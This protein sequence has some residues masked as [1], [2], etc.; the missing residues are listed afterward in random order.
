MEAVATPRASYLSTAI[1]LALLGGCAPSL[2][3]F[4]TAAVPPTG[5]SSAAVG[6][7]GSIPV[8]P[9]YDAYDTGKHVLE[10]AQAGQ[11]LTSE[12]KWQAFDAGM[13]L[14]LS[15]PS[16]GYHLSFAY[17]PW[18]RL[19]VSL[20]YAGSVLRLGSRYQVLDRAT[21]PFDMTVGLGVSRFTYDIPIGDYVPVLKMDDFT[22]WQLDVPLL[23]GMQN[24]W[25]RVW[26]GPRFLATFFDAA[27][28]LDLQVEEPVLASMSGR[29]YYVGG[30][31]GIGFGYRWVFLAFELTVT[32]LIGSA[33]FDAP[34]IQDS[35]SHT[36]DLSG[37]VIYPTLGLM[38]EF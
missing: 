23:I 28:R 5:H 26:V 20:R 1:M 3:T 10:K 33:Q 16:V 17:V 35:P 36:I 15:P 31:G 21:G 24:R 19:E 38:G 6:L 9:L 32:D 4:Q 34:A 29:A 8:G 27:L 30:Q 7:E 14:L 2:S 18:R 22:R 25:F 12:E 37:L 13:Q 11:A